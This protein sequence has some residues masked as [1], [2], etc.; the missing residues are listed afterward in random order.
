MPLRL[1]LADD[2][3]MVREALALLLSREPD[4]LVVAQTGN[5]TEVHDLV[6]HHAVDLVCMDI[7][8]PGMNG[9]EATRRLLA[10]FPKVRVLA[11][12]GHPDHRHVQEM[13]KVGALGYV[14]KT[15]MGSELVRAIRAVARDQL[16]LSPE[17][18]AVLPGLLTGGEVVG[19]APASLGPRE[20]QV[21]QLVAEGC[22]STEIADQLHISPFTVEV[23]RRNIMRK[24]DLHNVADI[25][26]YAIRTGLVLI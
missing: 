19:D 5:G 25:T 23:H 16:Y 15:E 13:L 3:Q 6:L 8:M 20:R 1:L 26:R 12:S 4:L 17:V 18:M 24:L 7:S 21:L 14:T 11:L 2:H 10:S 22:S 9:I